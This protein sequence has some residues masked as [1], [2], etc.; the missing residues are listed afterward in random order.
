MSDL[1]RS[2]LSLFFQL[3]KEETRETLLNYPRLF[4][5]VK[6]GV[7]PDVSFFAPLPLRC[8]YLFPLLFNNLPVHL[9]HRLKGSLREM[10][11]AHWVWGGG[12][13]P[14]RAG[15]SRAGRLVG[16]MRSQPRGISLRIRLFRGPSPIFVLHFSLQVWITLARG[17]Q[18]RQLALWNFFID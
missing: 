3:G 12:M 11:A 8:G 4:L 1:S 18:T 6:G 16:A 14:P 10:G 17:A 5:Q 7:L 2:L 9:V 13:M 15:E